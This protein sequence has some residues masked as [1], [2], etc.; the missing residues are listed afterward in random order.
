MLF[1]RGRL[2]VGSKQGDV[3]LYYQAGDPDPSVQLSPFRLT[4]RVPTV[5]CFWGPWMA[6]PNPP[7]RSLPKSDPR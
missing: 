3:M 5:P 4:T 6:V 1:R 2:S 7:A